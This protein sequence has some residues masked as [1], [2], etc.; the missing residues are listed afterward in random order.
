MKHKYI[1]LILIILSVS[2]L[3]CSDGPINTLSITNNAEYGVQLNFKG[4]LTEIPAGETANLTD[5]LD[6]EYEY[7]TLFDVPQGASYD[8]SESCEG[9][10]VLK[11]GT[12][13]LVVYISSFDGATYSLS[14]SI[15]TST[16]L[17]EDFIL[18]N[19]I[20]P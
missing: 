3:S 6:G 2:L 19:P 1:Y 9:T 12:K 7:K 5:I 10:F 18:P 14:A 17:S 16:N 11:A 20:G 4:T 13:I 15:T 8:A